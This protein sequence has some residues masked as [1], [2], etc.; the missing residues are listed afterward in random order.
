MNNKSKLFVMFLIGMTIVFFS[1]SYIYKNVP[2][3]WNLILNNL[4]SFE[5][6]SKIFIGGII[7]TFINFLLAYGWFKIISPASKK[8]LHYRE[9]LKTY[10]GSQIFRYIGGIWGFATIRHLFSRRLGVTHK[11]LV[12]AFFVESLFLGIS[13]L[14][15]SSGLLFFID[16]DF[17]RKYKIFIVLGF[18]ILGIN[19]L[20]VM[21]SKKIFFLKLSNNIKKIFK[22]PMFIKGFYFYLIYFILLSLIFSSFYSKNMEQ[23]IFMFFAFSWVWLVGF[24]TPGVAQG[25]GVREAIGILILSR[26]MTSEEA[27]FIMV[28]FRIITLLAD[29]FFYFIY[30]TLFLTDRIKNKIK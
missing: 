9:V 30:L 12:F 10:S 16:I 8:E 5:N 20:L 4:F 17:F 15:L 13:A 18:F 28:S 11:F 29:F 6:L 14:L 3:S 22:Y 25:L 7:A 23:G 26:I 2:S 27:L 19:L 21:F 24:I 1:L